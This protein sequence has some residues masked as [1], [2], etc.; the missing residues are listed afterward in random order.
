M[1]RCDF[2]VIRSG[3]KRKIF[4]N[5]VDI[6]NRCL[7]MQIKTETSEKTEIIL[8]YH[9]TSFQEIE[10]APENIRT[11]TPCEIQSCFSAIKNCL[12]GDFVL[13]EEDLKNYCK[14]LT[15]IE[16]AICFDRIEDCSERD[17]SRCA[18]YE[19]PREN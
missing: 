16:K 3:R 18:V 17:A 7:D 9:P 6:T 14:K 4:L 12:H 5:G 10:E 13:G 8:K 19:C 11:I 15:E 2:K 1:K